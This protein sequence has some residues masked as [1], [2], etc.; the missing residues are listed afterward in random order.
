[1]VLA[2]ALKRPIRFSMGRCLMLILI[3]IVRLVSL[4]HA[5]HLPCFGSLP[6]VRCQLIGCAAWHNSYNTILDW[7]PAWERT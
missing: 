6:Q 1:M 3:Q 7:T 4:R 5:D 2:H